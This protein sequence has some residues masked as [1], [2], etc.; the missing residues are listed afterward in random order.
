M[1]PL[2]PRRSAVMPRSGCATSPSRT[3]KPTNA[4][5]LNE[6]LAAAPSRDPCLQ[7]HRRDG[8]DE[9]RHRPPRPGDDRRRDV[10]PWDRREMRWYDAPHVPHG[11]ECGYMA[12]T[13]EQDA[14]LRRSL[15]PGRHRASADHRGAISSG[16]ARRSA[17]PAGLLR[18]RQ[19]TRAILERAGAR[20]SRTSLAC[21]HGSAWRGTEPRCFA[22]RRASARGRWLQQREC[23]E[24]KR[25]RIASS[26]VCLGSS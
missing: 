8:L 3:S 11:W 16:P 13:H 7:R 6:F 4:A 20:A 1:F 15:H 17:Q 2:V 10:D 9:R 26:G 18:A 23:G 25:R 24:G 14:A 5:S 19:N 12:E 22:P 21:M